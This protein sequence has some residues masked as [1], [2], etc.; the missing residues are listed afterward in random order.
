MRVRGLLVYVDA[1]YKLTSLPFFTFYTWPETKQYQ[2]ETKT[3]KRHCPLS[4]V[5]VK[6]HEGS[7]EGFGKTMQERISKR[8]L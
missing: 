3:N 7:P 4:P 6:I 2:K 1:L 5:Q 8:E